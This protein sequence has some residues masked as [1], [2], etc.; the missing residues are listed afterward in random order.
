M[1]VELMRDLLKIDQV[2]G[3]GDTQA[4]VEGEIL[5]PDVKPDISRILSVDGN[6]NI[7]GKE[8]VADKIVVDG[9]VN[10]K[11]LYASEAGDYPIYSMNASAGFSQKIDI[12]ETQP[13]MDMDVV[14]EIE[15][16]DFSVINERKISIKTVLNLTGKS[17]ATSKMEVLRGVEGLEDL[18]ILKN[19]VYYNDRI[20][21]N[22]SETIVRENFEID[23]NMPEIAEI[24]KC[25]AFAVEKEKQVTD[26][27]V[28][29]GGVVKVNT[30]YVA[31]DDRNSL[32]LLKHEIP[33]THFVEVTGAMKDMDSKVK[34][35]VDEV[36]TDVK[37]NI[38]GDRK[39]FEVEAMVKIDAIVND[40]EEKEV[41]VD[42]YSPSKKLKIDKKKVVFNQTVGKNASNM[43]VKEMLD[44]PSNYPEIFKVF[45]INTNPIITEVSMVEDKNIIEGIIEAD[46]L[47][48]SQDKDQSAH[49]F[50]QEIPFRHFVEV[51]GAREGMQTEVDIHIND[52][53]YSLINPEQIELKVNIGASC[54]VSKKLEIDVLVDAEELDEMVDL[55]KRPSITIYYVQ[56][57]DTLWKIA[58]RYHTTVDDLIKTN[59]IENPE[60]IIPGD[61]III[62]KTFKYKI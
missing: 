14:A 60:R 62:Q 48:I 18:Q 45:S 20:G 11:I 42:A 57:G 43:V 53:D 33:F 26:G 36:Y 47:Y 6:I 22:H 13:N 49:S 9:V 17:I 44:L 8:A 51:D 31:D 24:L 7:T 35:K 10:F 25:D 19:T 37:E 21:N 27:K 2:I 56:P 16:I 52:V 30:L 55:S 61:Q 34:L 40:I 50:R 4:L 3:E 32:F 58:K 39:I 29:V 46:V 5:V 15:H 38:D 28:I 41:V 59:N 1:A 12:P 54:I 23:E